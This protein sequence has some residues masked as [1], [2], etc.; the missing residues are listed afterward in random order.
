M[1]QISEA[2]QGKT[3]R[4]IRDVSKSEKVDSNIIRR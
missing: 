3:T 1:T 2:Q 4:E